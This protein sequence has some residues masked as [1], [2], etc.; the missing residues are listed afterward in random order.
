MNKPTPT[1]GGA[2]RVVD[3]QLIDESTEAPQI[4]QVVE[5]IYAHTDIRLGG[6]GLPV[7]DADAPTP[8]ARA[9]RST[10]PKE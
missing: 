6:P 5:P 1:S 7:P 2:W 10:K 8:T 9:V 4:T 3:G